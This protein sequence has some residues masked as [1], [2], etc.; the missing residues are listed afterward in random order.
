MKKNKNSRNWERER[1]KE[2]AC[3][4]MYAY[5]RARVWVTECI[6]VRKM[7]W[8]KRGKEA[9][10][11]FNW[12]RLNVNLRSE[13]RYKK[14]KKKNRVNCKRE[15]ACVHGRVYSI[16]HVFLQNALLE[17]KRIYLKFWEIETKI[18]SSLIVS[19]RYSQLLFFSYSHIVHCI[20][21]QL[22]ITNYEYLIIWI[23][24]PFSRIF[25]PIR[26]K[27]LHFIN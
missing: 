6:C 27:L 16:G 26:L 22:I 25:I 18:I 17:I 7:N 15:R 1:E 10:L 3:M 11:K 14:K 23:F 5:E 2:C 24:F 20:T 12:Y 8:K 21:K 9:S 19:Y 13:R 4:C